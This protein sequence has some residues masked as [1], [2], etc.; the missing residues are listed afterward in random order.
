LSAM[1]IVDEF[2]QSGGRNAFRHRQYAP[3]RQTLVAAKT[4]VSVSFAAE[5]YCGTTAA[6]GCHFTFPIEL[7]MP[8]QGR[9]CAR[10]FRNRSG[11]AIPIFL[12]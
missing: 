8:N 5:N 1:N 2:F 11:I 7:S 6:A 12:T 4:I 9:V 3:G 10:R